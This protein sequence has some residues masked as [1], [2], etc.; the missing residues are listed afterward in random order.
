MSFRD[1][2]IRAIVKT[3]KITNPQA[4]K[5]LT[6]T[7]IERRDKIGRYWFSRI[8]PIDKFKANITT[9]SLRL[10]FEDLG[11]SGNIYDAKQSYYEYSI[12]T[13]DGKRVIESWQSNTPHISISTQLIPV[14]QNSSESRVLKYKIIT[15]RETKKTSKKGT[16]V[17]ISLA[18]SGAKIVG[19]QR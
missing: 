2:D 11:V 5:Y 8:N 15:H 16:F 12:T 7:L 19:I 3:G 4:E 14:S 9:D 17:Y 13:V 6:N 10:S 1:E 18:T